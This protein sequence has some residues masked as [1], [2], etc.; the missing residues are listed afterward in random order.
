MGKIPLTL[1]VF[2]QNGKQGEV[3]NLATANAAAMAESAA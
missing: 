3:K 2:Q 1:D